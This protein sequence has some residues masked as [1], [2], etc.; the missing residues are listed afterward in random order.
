VAFG[1]CLSIPALE[2]SETL[3]LTLPQEYV[4][5][6]EGRYHFDL[7]GANRAQ[8]LKAGLGAENLSMSADCTRENAE[9]F[10]S[11]RRDGGATGRMAAC[12]HLE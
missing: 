7:R 10:Y 8:A 2:I 5:R 6:L 1:P 4:I 3:A 12:I 9:L 11:Y